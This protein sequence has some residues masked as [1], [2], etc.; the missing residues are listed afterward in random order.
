MQPQR[1]W[2]EIPQRYRLEAGQCRKCRKTWF[3]PRLKCPDCG[4]EAFAKVRLPTDGK[5]LTFTVVHTA[6][7]RFAKLAPYGIGIVELSNKVKLTAQIVD[8]E[9]EEL[10]TGMPVRLEFRKIHDV[11][12]AGVIC[13]GYKAVPA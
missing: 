5:L 10:K 2:R 8:V 13:Y 1:V 4:G 9:P 7:E 11:G 12:H 6:P 3:P